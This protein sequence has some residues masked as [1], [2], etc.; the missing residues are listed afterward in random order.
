MRRIARCTLLLLPLLMIATVVRAQVGRVAGSVT[1]E[2]GRPVHGATI[3]AHNPDQAPS[4][5]VSTSDAKGR[6]GI[7]GLRRGSWVFTIQAPGFEGVSARV[8]V[9][10][11][12]PNPPLNV[13]LA[14]GAAP[15]APGPLAGVDARDIQQRID[16]A[17][18]L[19]G[20]GDYRGALAAYR[21][22]VRRVPALTAVHLEIGR[23]HERLNDKESA[24]AAYRRL[25]EL[26]PANAGAQ[27]AIERLAAQ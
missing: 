13:K 9:V 11:T 21:E 24:L 1:G 4:T 8:D 23:L 25:L 22:L 10:T 7:L 12:R 5:Y 16:E 17:A 6:F 14:R 27:T 19:A 2:D 15:A 26:E 20:S 3:T 18:S